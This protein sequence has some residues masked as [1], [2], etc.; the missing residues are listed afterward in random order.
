MARYVSYEDLFEKRSTLSD[1]IENVAKYSRES[2]I[3][4]CAS[5]ALLL[6]IWSRGAFDIRQHDQLVDSFFMPVRASSLIAISRLDEP[7][8]VFHRRQLLLLAKLALLHCPEEGIDLVKEPRG[9]GDALLMANDQFHFDLQ[10]FTNEEKL[11]NTLTNFVPVIEYSV[12]RLESEIARSHLMLTQFSLRLKNHPDFIDIPESFLKLAGI[13]LQDYLALWFGLLSKYTAIDL[14]TLQKD[15]MELYIR[16]DFFRTTEVPLDMA[17]A[18]LEELTAT[19]EDL[20]KSF[21]QRDYGA[22][23]FTALRSK[24]LIAEGNG[25]VLSD[26]FF[27]IEKIQSGPYWRINDSSR[28]V[29]DRLRRFWGPVFEEYLLE[30]LNSSCDEQFNKYI[31]GPRFDDPTSEQVCDGM[32]LFGDSIVLLEYKSS[33]FRAES[34]YSGNPELLLHEIEE[35]LVATKENSPKG[36]RQLAAAVRSLFLAEKRECIRGIDL[37]GVHRVF[38]VLVTLDSIGRTLMMSRFLSEYFQKELGEGRSKGPQIMPLLSIYIEDLEFLSGFFKEVPFVQ[39]LSN[40]IERDPKLINTVLAVENPVLSK[41]GPRHNQM[42][43]RA[44][45]DFYASV[46]KRLA[47]KDS[48]ES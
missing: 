20:K 47:L 27:L 30:L 42:L 32:L 10:G 16:P 22:N 5:A 17:E 29:G 14:P 7:Q 9:F 6:K 8:Y 31:H 3:Y 21:A 4:V 37:K 13:P 18:F 19:P 36:V 38:P 1:L 15:W 44:F 23:D 28:P 34:K 2:V 25:A 26:M 48:K 11:L 41:L 45:D 46:M 12:F 43:D 24:P 40:W 35:K 33:M 39:I